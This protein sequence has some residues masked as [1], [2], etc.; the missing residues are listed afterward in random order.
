MKNTLIHAGGVFDVAQSVDASTARDLATFKEVGAQPWP[1]G[2][3]KIVGEAGRRAPVGYSTVSSGA[4]FS[5]VAASGFGQAERSASVPQR[6]GAVP[7]DARATMVGRVGPF[8]MT[9]SIPS[10][11]GFTPKG[12][13]LDGSTVGTG[14]PG[15]GAFFEAR[16][17]RVI[18]S[19]ARVRSLPDPMIALRNI[20]QAGITPPQTPIA[21]ARTSRP[22]RQTG[23]TS[24]APLMKTP[25]APRPDVN[26][27]CPPGFR[28]VVNLI[29]GPKCVPSSSGFGDVSR[30]P[31]PVSVEFS[32]P[33]MYGR[34]VFEGPVVRDRMAM[35]SLQ[36]PFR[37]VSGFGAGPDG[38]GAGPDGLGGCGCGAWKQS[39]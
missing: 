15:G 2:P 5:P 19:G 39:G 7:V 33:R 11:P 22:V 9:G 36:P 12:G 24:A 16:E 38:L 8:N 32:E 23:L 35:K 34:S 29:E 20:R 27:Q 6:I 28:T 25:A 4:R 30:R 13:I 31:L 1:P 26:N 14:Q 37:P 21:D 10:I 3:R 18:G 17:P